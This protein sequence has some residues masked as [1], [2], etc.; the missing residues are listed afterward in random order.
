MLTFILTPFFGA[1]A[2][3]GEN[4]SLRLSSAYNYRLSTSST[5][6]PLIVALPAIL[7]DT[8]EAPGT[9]LLPLAEAIADALQKWGQATF[10]PCEG[11][12]FSISLSLFVLTGGQ[13]RPIPVP[14]WLMR[15]GRNLP[16]VSSRKG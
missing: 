16:D 6:D 11:A 2:T 12:S 1:G 13:G 7:M 14:A 8:G 5:G 4:F 3:L 15:K 9:G 10:P